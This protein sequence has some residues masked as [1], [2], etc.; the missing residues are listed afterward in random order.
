MA[1]GYSREQGD[2]VR[3]MAGQGNGRLDVQTARKRSAQARIKESGP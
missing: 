3:E 2:E 1:A